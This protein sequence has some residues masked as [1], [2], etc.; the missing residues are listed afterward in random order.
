MPAR[1]SRRPA[2]SSS[3]MTGKVSTNSSSTRLL[4]ERRAKQREQIAGRHA[5][6]EPADD[7]GDHHHEHRVALEGKTD[8]HD[9]DAEQGPVVHQASMRPE[10]M[11]CQRRDCR[12]G[13]GQRFAQALRKQRGI[14]AIAVDA[15]RVRIEIEGTSA[16]RDHACRRR[17]SRWPGRRP[18][19][20]RRSR[21]PFLAA[22]SRGCH[23]FVA[24]IGESLVRDRR[25]ARFACARQFAAGE[26]DRIRRASK[27]RT[28]HAI[29]SA[30]AASRAAML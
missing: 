29:A 21:R 10:A 9:R 27:S 26:S 18:H 15:E 14:R 16:A 30:S 28:A 23:R 3:P 19:R 7:A 22:S 13:R 24:A 17:R 12:A 1:A 11:R 25:P 5:G 4:D 6:G 20:R 8:D 2:R